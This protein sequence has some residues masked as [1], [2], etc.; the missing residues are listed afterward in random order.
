MSFSDLSI[1]CYECSS[2]I[3]H[4]GLQSKL[5]ALHEAKFGVAHPG[6]IDIASAVAQQKE[7][8]RRKK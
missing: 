2:Y 1:W 4:G 5:N 6:S 8:R 3:A 7:K